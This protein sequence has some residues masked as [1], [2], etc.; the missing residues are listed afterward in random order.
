MSGTKAGGKKTYATMIDRHGS[1]FYQKIGK[2]GG[3]WKGK[4]GFAVRTDLAKKF[5]LEAITKRW[6]E[7]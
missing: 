7:S 1:D 3:Q 4:K 5:A 6:S 2:M